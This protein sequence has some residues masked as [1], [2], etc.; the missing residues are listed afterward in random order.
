MGRLKEYRKDLILI[1]A[2]LVGAGLIAGA[3]ALAKKPGAYV[4]VEQDGKMIAL[5]P[6]DEDRREVFPDRDIAEGNVLVIEGGRVHM[7]SASC[8]DKLC[9][10][11]GTRSQVG[12]TIVCLPHRLAVTVIS[13]EEAEELM[14]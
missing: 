1:L 9:V 8:P 13:R 5:Y 14:P 11:Q 3:I 10:K 7:E 4:R 12:E 6:L 2:V